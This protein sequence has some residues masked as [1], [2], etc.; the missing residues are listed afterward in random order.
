[1]SETTGRAIRFSL[2][3]A[4]VNRIDTLDRMLTSL[5][6]QSFC[7]YEL[8]L[9]DQNSDE[10]LATVMAKWKPLIPI[11]HV[12]A[13]VGLSRAR[14]IGIAHARGELLGFPD[15]DCWY[16]QDLL[17]RVDT[18]FDQ[19]HDFSLLC[20]AARSEDGSEV[21]SRWPR[22]SCPV[23][24]ATAFRACVSFGMFLCR[25]AV[26]HAGG[27]DEN[28]GL[29][30]GTHFQ[31]GEESDLALR[32]IGQ[33]RAGWFEKSMWAFHPRKDAA[34][35][36]SSRALTYGAGFGYVLRKHRYSPHIWLYHVARALAGAAMAAAALHLP[37]ARF[38]WNS[39]RGRI[40]GYCSRNVPRAEQ[41]LPRP[42]AR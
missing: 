3:L 35:A 5:A 40:N 34:T 17:A 9:V 8:I 7:D 33:G 27:F 18:W 15:D 30:S 26:T 19:H 38:Y 42:A 37:E 12:R 6:G 36:S 29:G 14:N 21:G 22:R 2:V 1:M 23:T 39:A 41:C 10:R 25:E 11:V 28:L 4:T 20:T 16:P 13:G 31:S 24:R 32:V